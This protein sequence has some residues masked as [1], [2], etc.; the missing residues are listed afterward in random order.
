[1][2]RGKP[3]SVLASADNQPAT[4]LRG[5]SRESWTVAAQL[6]GATASNLGWLDSS[7][8]RSHCCSGL[9]CLRITVSRWPG[10]QRDVFRQ[11]LVMSREASHMSRQKAECGKRNCQQRAGDPRAIFPPGHAHC[12]R[13]KNGRRQTG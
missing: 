5:H 4:L 1:M 7:N 12:T 8:S 6:E 3:E 9:H 2:V 10:L 13:G 11:I